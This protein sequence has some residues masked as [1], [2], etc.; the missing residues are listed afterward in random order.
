VDI[1]W[2]GGWAVV[3]IEQCGVCPVFEIDQYCTCEEVPGV[4][5]DLS[6][7]ATGTATMI[8]ARGFIQAVLNKVS[9]FGVGQDQH[10]KTLAIC[11]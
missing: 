9:S 7:P 5:P 1:H 2:L 3:M 8:L 10:V 4:H 11:L 6:A